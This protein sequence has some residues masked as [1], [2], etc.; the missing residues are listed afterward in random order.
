[1]VTTTQS[2]W[3]PNQSTT[4]FTS[5]EK[6]KPRPQH[7]RCA[8]QYEEWWSRLWR[9]SPLAWTTASVQSTSCRLSVP[10]TGGTTC[11]LCHETR[12]HLTSC[13]AWIKTTFVQWKCSVSILL[14]MERWVN[15]SL[16][17]V[18]CF[19]LTSSLAYDHSHLTTTHAP[20]VSTRSLRR[21]NSH[22]HLTTTRAPA[23]STRYL[24]RSN[25]HSH[26]TTTCSPAVSTWF[27]RRSNGHPHIAATCAH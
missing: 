17:I 22:S 3:S 4:Q 27:L 5:P 15:D 21:S 8:V 11:A 10:L 16:S 1:M 18:L 7:T 2:L 20:A 25:G 6:Q 12:H 14:G 24:R 19:S 13:S 26:L 23:V 9:Q